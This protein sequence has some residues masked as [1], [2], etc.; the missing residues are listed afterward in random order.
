M[1]L[2][3]EDLDDLKALLKACKLTLNNV[4]DVKGLLASINANYDPDAARVRAA[5]RLALVVPCTGAGVA[6]AVSLLLISQWSNLGLYHFLTLTVLWGTWGLVSIVATLFAGIVLLTRRR[7][8]V[9]AGGGP[10]A[11]PALGNGPY[12]TGITAERPLP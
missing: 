3:I 11:P 8:R 6:G 9:A 12:S 2:Q 4:D 7:A 1:S 5:K 10:P